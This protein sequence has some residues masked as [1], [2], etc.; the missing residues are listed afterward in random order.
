MMAL[1]Y[2]FVFLL[3]FCFMEF[4]AWFAHKYLMHGVLWFLH[5]DHHV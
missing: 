1:F 5:E 2:L 3:S 4:M